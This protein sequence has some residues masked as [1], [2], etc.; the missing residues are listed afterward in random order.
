MKLLPTEV[1]TVRNES[2]SQINRV[3]LFIIIQNGA[4]CNSYNLM[5]GILKYFFDI[6]LLRGRVC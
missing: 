4:K 1:P 3:E 5:T 2:N 6:V